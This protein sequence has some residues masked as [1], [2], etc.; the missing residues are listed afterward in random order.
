[1]AIAIGGF[2]IFVG[3]IMMGIFALGLLGVIGAL[4]NA[5]YRTLALWALLIVGVLDLASGVMLRRE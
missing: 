4:E 3:V 2:L 1:M 5:G